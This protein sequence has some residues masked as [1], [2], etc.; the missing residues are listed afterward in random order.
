MTLNH[1]VLSFKH[2]P[3]TLH[4]RREPFK[5][6]RQRCVVSSS[7][8]PAHYNAVELFRDKS[9][10]SVELTTSLRRPVRNLCPHAEIT[11]F[12]SVESM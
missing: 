3:T 7:C 8:R 11:D 10:K 5:Y 1:R 6:I 9:C 12:E 4:H 2:L